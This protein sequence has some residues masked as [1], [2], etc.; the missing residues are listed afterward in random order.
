MATTSTLVTVITHLSSSCPRPSMPIIPTRTRSF[1][2][3]TLVGNTN[4]AAVPKASPL[5]NSLRPIV[6][7]LIFFLFSCKNLL[8]VTT[9]ANRD[10]LQCPDPFQQSFHS[11]PALPGGFFWRAGAT[12]VRLQADGKLVSITLEG[13]ELPF[14]IDH[15]APHARPFITLAGAFLHSVF[16]SD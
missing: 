4:M 10:C 8:A 3:N 2:P 7:S 9:K 16:S 11:R 6:L 15:A 5:M 14:P 1:A 13:P 12:P